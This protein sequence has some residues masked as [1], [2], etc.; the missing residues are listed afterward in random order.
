MGITGGSRN[1]TNIPT[2]E[3]TGDTSNANFA[4]IVN[5][6][7]QNLEQRNFEELSNNADY[8]IRSIAAEKDTNT[9]RRMANQLLAAGLHPDR[10]QSLQNDE[11]INILNNLRIKAGDVNSIINNDL[12]TINKYS[13]P[14]PVNNDSSNE[15][16]PTDT[17]AVTQL[18][19]QQAQLASGQST[20][21]TQNSNST[22]APRQMPPLPNFEDLDDDPFYD[23]SGRIRS[24]IQFNSGLAYFEDEIREGKYNAALARMEKLISITN[25]DDDISSRENKLRRILSKTGIQRTSMNRDDDI[26]ARKFHE[27]LRRQQEKQ[28][29]LNEAVNEGLNID[30]STSIFR[31]VKKPKTFAGL[32]EET[33][34]ST[35]ARDLFKKRVLSVP[36]ISVPEAKDDSYWVVKQAFKINK[37]VHQARR[38]YNQLNGIFEV[39]NFVVGKVLHDVQKRVTDSVDGVKNGIKST[40]LVR[41]ISNATTKIYDAAAEKVPFLRTGAPSIIGRVREA[42]AYTT[43]GVNAAGYGVRIGA[44]PAAA[45]LVLTGSPA[46]A[47]GVMGAYA[48]AN[49]V[50]K[51]M[52]A[53]SYKE[54]KG[55]P[56]IIQSAS[57]GIYADFRYKRPLLVNALKGATENS[58]FSFL[59]SK[60]GIT[61]FLKALNWGGYGA[62]AGVLIGSAVGNPAIGMVAGSTLGAGLGYAKGKWDI[63]PFK[64]KM[65]DR[66]MASPA[67]TYLNYGYNAAWIGGIVDRFKNKYG[68]NLIEFAKGEVFS[69][70]LF[71]NALG[72]AGYASS[73]G[74]INT[75]NVNIAGKFLAS[76]L[77]GNI[78]GRLGISAGSLSTLRALSGPIGVGATIGTVISTAIVLALGGG[79]AS[80]TAVAIGA[81]AGGVIGGVIGG[82]I[83]SGFAGVGA[84]PGAAIGSVVGSTISGTLSGLFVKGS[85]ED[86]VPNLKNALFG[87]IGSMNAIFKLANI[88]FEKWNI[89]TIVGFSMAMITLLNVLQSSSANNS[90]YTN[91][92]EGAG[93]E[94]ITNYV[95]ASTEPSLL[96]VIS[97]PVSDEKTIVRSAIENSVKN[98]LE[99]LK[100]IYPELKNANDEIDIIKALQD[101][102]ELYKF[103]HS[104][105]N[106]LKSGSLVVISD[107]ADSPTN[108]RFAILYRTNKDVAIVIDK[109]NNNNKYFLSNYKNNLYLTNGTNYI[110]SF[111]NFK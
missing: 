22:P 70:M 81:T 57:R 18:P 24:D 93:A 62:L 103:N 109:E 19:Q 36:P 54:F 85:V 74:A 100:T 14:R 41:G 47:I 50:T 96:N 63:S 79:A 110:Y 68:G 72:A 58:K 37:R 60:G 30:N 20:V 29:Q 17:N 45:A 61:P 84:A 95:V 98:N 49:A 65:M 11:N 3:V 42:I 40:R 1:P 44:A 16:D 6:I 27:F 106:Y 10:Y 55:L 33:I 21:G 86:R 92:K 99:L 107:K 15:I 35:T 105:I 89:E 32:T 25:T 48:G 43:K 4:D 102:G 12:P 34:Q 82:I 31:E 26:T 90:N 80:L 108:T 59:L 75:L 23:P 76:N 97:M 56:K 94:L 66:L 77:A 69:P 7:K 101:N 52:S 73:V 28:R 67:M 51:F 71:S 111:G 13:T 64:G 83:G 53:L 39:G 5:I 8:A 88:D 87:V 91:I 9:K 38:K 46:A 78:L 2:P 104:S